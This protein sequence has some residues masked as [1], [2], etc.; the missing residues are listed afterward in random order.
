MQASDARNL[1]GSCGLFCG[2]CNKYQS[3]APSRCSGCQW[4]EQHAW[5]SIW[6]CCVRKHGF[7]TCAECEDV[8]VCPI[9][10]RRNVAGWIPAAHNLQQIIETGAGPWLE[11]QRNRQALLENLLHEFNEG[12]SMTFYCKACARMPL[13]LLREAVDQA[14]AD[15]ARQN[16]DPVDKKSKARILKSLIER[17]AAQAAI[18]LK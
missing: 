11:E 16:I 13:D 12:R 14:R 7:A 1:I 15:L 4:G 6:V 18:D 3:T 17:L 2:L 9:F 10:I 5:C 8:F